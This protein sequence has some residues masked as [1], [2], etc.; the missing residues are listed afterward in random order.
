MQGQSNWATNYD[1]SLILM[2]VKKAKK[3]I[4]KQIIDDGLSSMAILP[5]LIFL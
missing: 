1:C 4:E 5:V 2:K 3:I